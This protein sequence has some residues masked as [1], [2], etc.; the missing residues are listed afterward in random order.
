MSV[1]HSQVV[2]SCVK[3]NH[4]LVLNEKEFEFIASLGDSLTVPKKPV[5][6]F[7]HLSVVVVMSAT[8]GHDSQY[9]LS[10]AAK[11]NSFA[12]AACHVTCC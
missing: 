1:C 7:S 3:Y 2:K 5:R 8:G 12:V 11:V 4:S 10:M 9:S 6:V